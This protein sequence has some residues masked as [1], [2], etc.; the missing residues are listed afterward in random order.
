MIGAE[1]PFHYKRVFTISEFTLN[2]MVY[3]NIQS[4]V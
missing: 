2:G 4:T 1:K 3:Y